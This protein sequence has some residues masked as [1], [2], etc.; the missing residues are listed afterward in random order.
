MT[1]IS[2]NPHTFAISEIGDDDVI[3]GLDWIK[4]INPIINW[5]Q[6][7]MRINNKQAKITYRSTRIQNKQ[8]NNIPWKFDKKKRKWYNT[9]RRKWYTIAQVKQDT[10]WLDWFDKDNDDENKEYIKPKVKRK[11]A[12][13]LPSMTVEYPINFKEEKDVHMRIYGKHFDRAMELEEIMQ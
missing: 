9:K 12:M 5:K 2:N 13:T 4:K 7:Y 11:R 10:E 8:I 6:G 1:D 3:I